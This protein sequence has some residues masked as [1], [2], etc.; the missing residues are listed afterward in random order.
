MLANA[1]NLIAIAL[2]L[3]DNGA[4]RLCLAGRPAPGKRPLAEL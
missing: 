3:P 4:G 2:N 1:L